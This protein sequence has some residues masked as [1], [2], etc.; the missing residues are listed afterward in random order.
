MCCPFFGRAFPMTQKWSTLSC[1]PFW[2]RAS[3]ISRARRLRQLRKVDLLGL[4][5][6]PPKRAVECTTKVEYESSSVPQIQECVIGVGG[7]G[8]SSSS[9]KGGALTWAL[10]QRG[11]APSRHRSF[12]LAVHHVVILR[13]VDLRGGRSPRWR[14]GGVGAGGRRPVRRPR[15]EPDPEPSSSSYCRSGAREQ[16]VVLFS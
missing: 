16:E 9:T 15:P 5:E 4:D 12:E 8:S 14:T 11:S 13:E 1:H 2:L 7:V 10:H 3:S 6:T